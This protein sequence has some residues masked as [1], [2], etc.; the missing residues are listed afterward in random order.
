MPTQHKWCSAYNTCMLVNC[1]AQPLIMRTEGQRYCV[2]AEKGCKIKKE[3]KKCNPTFRCDLLLLQKSPI[4]LWV[5]HPKCFM[6]A[7]C[8]TLCINDTK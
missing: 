2:G 4:S 1:F 6:Y 3:R 5:N 7:L 8:D